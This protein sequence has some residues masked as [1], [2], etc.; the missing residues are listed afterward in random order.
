[1]PEPCPYCSGRRGSSLVLH[2]EGEA[3]IEAIRFHEAGHAVAAIACGGAVHSIRARADD[4]GAA[5]T[6]TGSV[7]DLGVTVAAGPAA[8]NWL[9]RWI[10]GADTSELIASLDRAGAGMC[11]GCDACRLAAL[12]YIGTGDDDLA[13][14][15][16]LHRRIE[17]R[18]LDLIRSGPIWRAIREVAAALEPIGEIAGEV[19]HHICARHF[20]PGAYSIL[21]HPN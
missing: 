11:G 21:H 3:V 16:T 20:Q 15:I 10:V 17:G 6:L 14:A 1:M 19:V 9:N 8:G 18:A 12:L 2:C 7:I 5:V 13:Q 4:A